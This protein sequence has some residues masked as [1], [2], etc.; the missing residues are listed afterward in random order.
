MNEEYEDLLIRFRKI[1]RECDKV[2]GEVN[3]IN[4]QLEE[5]G[6]GPEDDIDVFIENCKEQ[7]QVVRKQYKDVVDEVVILLKEF[8]DEN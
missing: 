7:L 1:E 8:E 6:I 4:T 3:A 5:L 2:K